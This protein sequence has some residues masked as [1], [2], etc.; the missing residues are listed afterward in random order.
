MKVFR[1]ELAA[2]RRETVEQ[3]I[4]FGNYLAPVIAGRRGEAGFIDV[5][6]RGLPIRLNVEGVTCKELAEL[7]DD[8]VHNRDDS[9]RGF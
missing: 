3:Q 8:V 9:G 5:P 4:R 6:V 2:H 1:H 7:R